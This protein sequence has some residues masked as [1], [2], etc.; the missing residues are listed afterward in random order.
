MK[1]RITIYHVFWML[2]SGVFLFAVLSSA[3]AVWLTSRPYLVQSQRDAAE[4]LV[5]REA[6]RLDQRIEPV[7]SL[8]VYIASE[9]QLISFVMGN[10]ISIDRTLDRLDDLSLPVG[11]RQIYFFDYSADVIARYDAPIRPDA[12]GA[13]RR[14]R[15]DAQAGRLAERVLGTGMQQSSWMA[16][17]ARGTVEQG[18]IMIAVPVLNGGLPEGAVVAVADITPGTD[19]PGAARMGALFKIVDSTSSEAA[20]A[21]HRVQLAVPGLTM[22]LR[23]DPS[24][25]SRI[26]QELISSTVLAVALALFLPFAAFG[27]AGRHTILKPHADLEASRNKLRAQQKELTEL[28]SIARKA[29][30]AILITDMEEKIVWSNPAFSRMTGYR[31][32]ELIGKKPGALLQ[33]PNTDQREVDQIR[34]ALESTEPVRVELVNYSK[35]GFPYWAR[36]SIAPLFDE[37]NNPYGYMSISSD[38]SERK[39]QETRLREAREAIEHQALHDE[40]T[41]LANRR[42]FNAVFEKRSLFHGAAAIAV[43]RID[44]DHFKNVNDTMGHEA[45]DHVLCEVARILREEVREKDLAV[46]VGGDEFIIL[47]EPGADIKR[48]CFVAETIRAR[49]TSPIP[50]DGKLIQTGASF[51]IACSGCGL[52]D[53][54]DLVRAADSALYAAKSAGRNQLAV[55]DEQLHRSAIETRDTAELIRLGLGRGEF[56]PYYQPQ[57]DAG[58]R[59]ISGVEVLARWK[60]PDK[61]LLTPAAFLDVAEQLSLLNELDRMVTE[62]ALD[63]IKILEHAG[64]APPKIS[65]NVTADRIADPEL[66]AMVSRQDLRQTRISFEILESVFLD[67]RPEYLD[68]A[69]DLIR[70][71]GLLLE[72]DDFGSGH[73]SMIS[74]MQVNPDVLKIDQRLV[75]GAPDSDVCRDMVRSIIDI[76]RSLGI[77]V[78]AEGVETP[79]HADLMMEMGCNTLQGYHF[80]EPLSFEELSDFLRAGHSEMVDNSSEGAAG[81]Q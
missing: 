68:F 58:T 43:I 17:E 6:A 39:A 74:L 55:Y 30:E 1:T 24:L 65:F 48:A 20:S 31:S 79:E 14:E 11:L 45:G 64:L 23:T 59:K 4:I 49:I 80:A 25:I 8:S 28:A 61:G 41:G 44:L 62:K 73:A 50:Y 37:Q 10:T 2:L 67:D 42:R 16:A 26:G 13:P 33:G 77:A 7:T 69:L 34:I 12:L 57:F 78:T 27:W 75:L 51:G 52:V 71:Q 76:S 32:D 35:L 21:D 54:P 60:Q 18:Q 47:L 40:L 56:V 9:P 3:A 22:V 46:R 66:V 38:V 70:D 72:I 29:E 19:G 63:D 36:I 5:E 81:A 53:A 15:L